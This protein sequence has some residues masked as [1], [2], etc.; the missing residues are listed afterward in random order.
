MRLILY[1]SSCVSLSLD[2]IAFVLWLLIAYPRV[3]RTLRSDL[4][5]EIVAQIHFCKMHFIFRATLIVFTDAVLYKL[6][7]KHRLVNQH[8]SS[9][10]ILL[11]WHFLQLAS[12][13]QPNRSMTAL[14]QDLHYWVWSLINPE[15]CCINYCI[16]IQTI[17]IIALRL[18]SFCYFRTGMPFMIK[19]KL[20]I[21]FEYCRSC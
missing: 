2:Q 9:F 12:F 7:A 8:I 6:H 11:N 18:N 17:T 5:A 4:F 15:M 21:I 13:C 16:Q 1:C 20:D 14:M 10:P 3:L 19:I